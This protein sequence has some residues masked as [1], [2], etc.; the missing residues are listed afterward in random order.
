VL[1]GHFKVH[2]VCVDLL[3]QVVQRVHDKSK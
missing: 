3:L 2:P 1:Q